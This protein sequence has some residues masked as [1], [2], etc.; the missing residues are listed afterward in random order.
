MTCQLL[1]TPALRALLEK[2]A[3]ATEAVCGNGSGAAS[4]RVWQITSR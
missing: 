3:K 4:V 1:L 2:Q